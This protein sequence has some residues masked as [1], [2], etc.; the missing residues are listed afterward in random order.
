MGGRREEEAGAAGQR[1]G[2]APGSRLRVLAIMV[3]TVIAV[4]AFV[5][6]MGWLGGEL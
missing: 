1:S 6:L 4:G 2:S 5:V 3:A